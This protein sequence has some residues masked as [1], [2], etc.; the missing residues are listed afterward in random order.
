M[1]LF[2]LFIAGLAVLLLAASA[3]PAADTPASGPPDLDRDVLALAAKIDRHIARRWEEEKVQPAAAADDA[4]F[5]RRVYLDLAGRIPSVRETRD[6]LDDRAADK[7][8]RLVRRLLDGQ[9]YV[10]HFVNVWRSLMLPEQNANFQAR[11]VV[12]GFT[13]WLRT[14]L[15][16]NAGYDRMVREL[17]TA[18][19]GDN[20]GRVP[21]GFPGAGQPAS[22]FGFYVAKD[23]K[24]ENLA[25]STARL[26]LGIRLEC[27][28]CHNHPFASWKREQF[29][30]YAAFFAGITRQGQGDFVVP[31]R[32]MTDRREL[33]IPGTDQVVQARFPDGKEPK[34]KFKASARETLA[35]WVTAADNPFFARAAVNRMWSYFFGTGLIDPVDEMV[36]AEHTASHPELLD[37]LAR[38]FASH[39]FDL[40]FLIQAITASKAYQLSSAGTADGEEEA[41]L[42]ARMPL[43]GLSAEQL[44]DS[45]AEATGFQDGSPQLPPGVVV[46]GPGAPRD[47]FLAKFA[48]RS[49]KSTEVQTSILQ[50]L[51]LMNGR[52]VADATS[53]ERSETLA[54]VADAPFMDTRQR[55]ETLYLAALARKPTAKELQRTVRYV[56]NGGPPDEG[57]TPPTSTDRDRKYKLALADVFWTLLNSGEFFLNH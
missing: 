22:P 45:V 20:N 50:A 29:W 35:D 10:T 11:F 5:V 33:T 30:G 26:F 56:E 40:K 42:F 38:E 21:F 39:K 23:L 15:A 3:A 8:L 48:N 1:R 18:S 49:E 55:I 12:P 34:W 2:G 41:R 14:Q 25:A 19:S 27:A 4:E 9:R 54:S 7:R 28:Q 31:G 37:E 47:E 43:R 32:E 36:G 57:E 51:S 52:I 46:F 13:S 24:P 16:K 17:L 53:L 6:F 44:F